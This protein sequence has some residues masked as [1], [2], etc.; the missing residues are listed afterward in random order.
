MSVPDL[1]RDNLVALLRSRTWRLNNL[2]YIEDK[3]GSVVKFKPNEAQLKL[4]NNLHTRNLC[5]K[6]R[7]HGIT[8]WACIRSLDT[9]MFKSNISCGIVAHTKTDALKFFNNKILFAYERL[10]DWLKNENPIVR[11]DMTGEIIFK[12][13]SRIVV[14]TSLRSGT[15]Q[16]V[17]ISELG[18]MVARFPMRAQE[19]I[20]GTLN[21]VDSDAIVTIEST[22]EGAWGQFYTMSNRAEQLD[23]KVRAGEE[24][25]TNLDYK[26]FF[27][28]WFE[29]TTNVLHEDVFISPALIEYFEK[30]QADTGYVLSTPQKAWYAKKAE[31]QGDSM[32]SQ[33]PSTPEEAFKASTEGTYYGK[34]LDKAE[35]EGRICNLPHI[36]G[37][38]VNTFWD[39]GRNDTNSIWFHQ[40]V[41]HWHHFINYYENSGESAAHYAKHLQEMAN[42]H[43]YVYGK[44]YLP[45]DA[46]VTEYTNADNKKRCDVLADLG[47]KP[48][49]IVPRI[50]SIGE[51]IEMTRNSIPRCKFDKNLCGEMKPGSGRG[52][53]PALRAY[54]KEFNERGQCWFNTPF[55]DWSS[56][57]AD[58]FRQHAQ[59]YKSSPLQPLVP[60]GNNNK[61]PERKTGRS[62]ARWRVA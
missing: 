49:V 37:I 54:R 47:V 32:W 30:V 51:G 43:G 14:G 40:Q 24:K 33:F 55:H 34:L 27:L 17:H 9:A 23:R 60:T 8:T 5:L 21:A 15:Y 7:Q 41:G 46:E 28:A 48:Y 1:T 6:S 16:R 12:N 3:K 18:P 45:H 2:Y 36:P 39:I 58:A 42:K 56:N 26:F 62:V 35:I 50:E 52:G 4:D 29:D 11:K 44:H 53:I 19:T 61:T 22:A 57:G 20:G 59:S 10:P 25:L 31:E 13:G 38:P